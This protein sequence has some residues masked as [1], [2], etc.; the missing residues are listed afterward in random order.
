MEHDNKDDIK[1]YGTDMDH[2]SY[3][4]EILGTIIIICIVTFLMW[5][6]S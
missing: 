5:S 2:S 3:V 6:S 4:P 1:R